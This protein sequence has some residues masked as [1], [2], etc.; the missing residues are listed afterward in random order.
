MSRKILPIAH[1][2]TI[3][4]IDEKQNRDHELHEKG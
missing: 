2:R 3:E 1:K 4:Q